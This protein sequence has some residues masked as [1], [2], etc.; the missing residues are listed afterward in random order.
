MPELRPGVIGGDGEVHAHI[1]KDSEVKA[2]KTDFV[3]SSD[4]K[5]NN[6]INSNWKELASNGG[7]VARPKTR[8]MEKSLTFIEMRL[9]KHQKSVQEH[10]VPNFKR[11]CLKGEVKGYPLGW[12]SVCGDIF[13]SF[14][15]VYK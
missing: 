1:M 13:H 6:E 11:C 10:P 8:L 7:W 9:T 3:L 12:T 5:W 14:Q 15:A 2:G 4:G